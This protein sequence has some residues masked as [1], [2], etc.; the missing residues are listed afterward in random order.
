ME[1]GSNAAGGY[2]D[3][4]A[5][6]LLEGFVYGHV[7]EIEAIIRF[8][9]QHGLDDDNLV[10]LLV[11][12]LK[13]NEVLVQRLLSAIDAAERVIDNSKQAGSQ[14]RALAQTLTAQM[15]EVAN[16]NAGRL[17]VAADRL[18]RS[19]LRAEELSGNVVAASQDLQRARG[20]FEQ[21]VGLSDGSKAM[22]SLLDHIRTQARVDLREYHV[23]VI[24]ELERTVGREAWAI[25]VYGIVG[26]MV[27]AVFIL[28]SLA[29]R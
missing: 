11:S 20:A 13:V 28:L 24:K 18:T 9:R 19:I 2:E 3:R 22:D 5:R 29:T 21:A 12:V 15:A 27:L 10:F 4:S 8:A 16:G 1:N 17:N 25:H 26:L 7:A 6:A 14:L 23:E